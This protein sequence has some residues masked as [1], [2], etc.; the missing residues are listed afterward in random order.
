MRRTDFTYDAKKKLWRKQLT[1]NG[2]RKVFSGKSKQDVMLKLIA[3]QKEVT[4]LPTFR[5]VADKWE[6]DHWQSL[7]QGSERSYSAPLRRIVEHFGDQRMD[8]I[9]SK[10]IQMWFARLGKDFSEKSVKQHKVVMNLIYKYAQVEMEMDVDNPVSRAS[11]PTGLKHSSRDILTNAQKK[12]VS[13]PKNADSFILPFLIYFTG[14]RCGEALALQ[15]QDVDFERKLIYVTKQVVHQPN[16]PVIDRPK[17][18][19]GNRVIPLLP[20]LEEK[21]RSL[22]LKPDDYITSGTPEPLSRSALRCRWKKWCKENGLLDKNGKPAIDRH[23]IRHQ[24]ATTLYEAGIEA[25]SAQ[26]LLGHADISTTLRIYTHISTEQFS[27][28]AEKLAK[29]VQ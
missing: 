26:H 29:F 20:P 8:E 1:I 16:L 6:E 19:N 7:R 18:E 2:V 21:I 27:E 24:Y 10:E 11:V 22:K 15:R 13:D 28:D 5:E 3:Y 9:T 25:K 14:L 17:T 23:Q 12:I 4:Q